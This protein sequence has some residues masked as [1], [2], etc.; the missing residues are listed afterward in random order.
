LCGLSYLEPNP[1]LEKLSFEFSGQHVHLSSDPGVLDTAL[2]LLR[3]QE[4]FPVLMNNLKSIQQFRFTDAP[5][6]LAIA[7]CPIVTRAMPFWKGV[8]CVTFRIDLSTGDPSTD[9]GRSPDPFPGLLFLVSTVWKCCP[10]LQEFEYHFNWDLIAGENLTAPPTNSTQGQGPTT[11]SCHPLRRL[12]INTGAAD[13]TRFTL[14]PS[15]KADIAMFLDRLF[16][17][18]N[19]LGGSVGE[20]WDDVRILVKEF[21]MQRIRVGRT[22]D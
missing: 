12:W 2:E 8:T 18:L 16:P 4:M 3:G 10:K 1:N 14:S 13:I 15:R 11:N 17:K 9:V 21:Q 7:I 5:R 19:D 6:D 20:L 22:E